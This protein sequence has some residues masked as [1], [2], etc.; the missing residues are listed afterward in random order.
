M[1]KLRLHS[2]KKPAPVNAVT[3]TKESPPVPDNSVPSVTKGVKFAVSLFKLFIDHSMFSAV[4]KYEKYRR[5]R[6]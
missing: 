2:W 6:S 5:L 3:E 1:E 4:Q